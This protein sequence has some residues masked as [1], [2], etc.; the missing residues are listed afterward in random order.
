MPS[1][2]LPPVSELQGSRNFVSTMKTIC[3]FGGSGDGSLN[4]WAFNIIYNNHVYSNIIPSQFFSFN[5]NIVYYDKIVEYQG[6]EIT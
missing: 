6:G 4:D 1:Y 5:S 3:K 2:L